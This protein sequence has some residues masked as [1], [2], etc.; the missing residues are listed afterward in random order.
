VVVCRAVRVDSGRPCVAGTH[1]VAPPGFE[2]VEE[3]ADERGVDV[4]HIQRGRCCTELALRMV[5]Q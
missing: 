3:A 2:V 5:E 1:A 4:G